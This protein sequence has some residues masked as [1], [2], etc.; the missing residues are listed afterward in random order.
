MKKL[1]ISTLLLLGTFTMSFGQN[2]AR[3]TDYGA[4]KSLKSNARI[5]PSTL[6]MELSIPIAV[7]PG[8]AGSSLPV[9]FD[10]S[11]KVW[12]LKPTITSWITPMGARVTDAQAIF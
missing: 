12:E 3:N 8:R 2:S 9:A 4:D 1:A 5:N 6:A 7:Y 11:S 10:Y